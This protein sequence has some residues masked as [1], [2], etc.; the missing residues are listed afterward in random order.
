MNIFF[1][2]LF[3]FFSLT[4]NGIRGTFL[5]WSKSWTTIFN[6]HVLWKWSR[7]A[8]RSLMKQSHKSKKSSEI[9]RKQNK[10]FSRP[11]LQWDKTSVRMI[12][13]AFNS[14][15]IALS[16]SQNIGN[17]LILTHYQSLH[18]NQL[19]N[20]HQLNVGSWEMKWFWVQC[21]VESIL[22]KENARCGPQFE[23]T[24]W[25][26]RWC[27]S[28]CTCRKLDEFGYCSQSKEFFFS[29]SFVS[30]SRTFDLM[31]TSAHFFSNDDSEISCLYCSNFR[32][33]KSIVQVRSLHFVIV[34]T[35]IWK[36]IISKKWT[37]PLPIDSLTFDW[38]LERWKH[39]E[40][41]QSMG[42][43]LI[44]RLLDGPKQKIR[45]EFH[46]FWPTN[47]L[48]LPGLTPSLVPLNLSLTFCL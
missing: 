12:W 32:C 34:Q 16:I 47:V 39:E 31:L 24:R 14:L 22:N 23:W 19:F 26:N 46:V 5:N 21:G 37:S 43:F 20:V 9:Q 8:L 11:K 18:F 42:S 4:E 13:T 29:F 36:L 33:W 44:L 6:M 17:C 41:L 1:T 25:R 2:S 15:L 45:V 3:L 30:Y 7:I 48:S 27:S 38:T 10:L 28:H 35:R 40:I